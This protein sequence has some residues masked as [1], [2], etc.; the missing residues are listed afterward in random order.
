MS[1]A[2]TFKPDAGNAATM[3]RLN[4]LVSGIRQT[5][6]ALKGIG[7]ALVARAQLT[8]REQRDPWGAA[9]A[10]LSMVTLMRRASKVKGGAFTKRRHKFTGEK[11]MRGSA[12]R[13]IGSA[14]ALLDTGRLRN[15]LTFNVSGNTVTVGTNVVY[16]GPLQYGAAKR[17]FKGVAPWGNVP[18]RAFLPSRVR[19]RLD[20]PADYSTELL[21]IVAK[22]LLLKTAG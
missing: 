9:W 19:G 20:L 11:I 14:K 22:H 17:S 3:R 16:A 13:A 4:S 2:V 7:N 5:N 21:G 12:V 6:P 15:S 18:A 8:F 1:L 10:P